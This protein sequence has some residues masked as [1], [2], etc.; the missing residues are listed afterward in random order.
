MKTPLRKRISLA[1]FNRIRSTCVLNRNTMLVMYLNELPAEF[2][3]KF[4]FDPVVM[5][6]VMGYEV[7][8]YFYFQHPVTNG[9]YRIRC[10]FN[11]T[12]EIPP[13]NRSNVNKINWSLIETYQLIRRYSSAFI[14]APKVIKWDVDNIKYRAYLQTC[15]KSI[16]KHNPKVAE[17]IF[18]YVSST[19][20]GGDILLYK[21]KRK[22]KR[23]IG[24]SE[25]RHE[26]E[27]H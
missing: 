21:V 19:I 25:K 8:D 10:L 5:E 4:D 24:I 14:L 23:L 16:K 12:F 18:P 13:S 1:K 9:C 6:D 3:V 7:D 15:F 11:N 2:R 27:K 17:I 26:Y 22:F 20:Y